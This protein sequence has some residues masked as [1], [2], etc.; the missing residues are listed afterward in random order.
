MAVSSPT[1]VQP[2]D[3]VY[4]GGDETRPPAAAIHM[5]RHITRVCIVILPSCSITA[6][7][8]ILDTL[9]LAN[10]LAGADL[11]Q[12][13]VL[14]C[15]GGLL[16]LMPNASI[17]ADGVFDDLAACDWLIV[18]GD[19]VTS[20]C[21]SRIFIG[22]LQR[23]AKRTSLI[24]GVGAGV[25]WLAEA[26]LLHGYRVSVRWELFRSF[27]RTFAHTV[28]SRRIYELDRDRATCAG[29]GATLDFMLAIIG[30]LEGQGLA[31]RVAE[32]FCLS[33]LRSGEQSQAIPG[34][35]SLFP[36]SDPL[37]DA[38]R[39]MEANL[40]EPLSTQE[41]ADAVRVSK[42]H[43]E[44]LFRQYL[45]STPAKYY[46]SLRLDGARRELR[47]STKPVGRISEELGFSSPTQFCCTYRRLYG[48]PPTAERRERIRAALV[49]DEIE[50]IDLHH[51]AEFA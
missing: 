9:R 12:V 11:Y 35:G 24:A 17:R 37:S 16:N 25:W 32:E 7:A 13:S 45:T 40:S 44:R 41:L 23:V 26:G 31:G 10:S 39:I 46:L 30:R 14:S 28:A 19:A 48:H 27:C 1:G 5:K 42:R 43:L 51:V 8:S 33:E 15:T 36:V 3:A 22:R 34:T 38:L 4:F 2:V 20:F 21:D 29:G 47:S 49:R 6:V 50:R 18:A